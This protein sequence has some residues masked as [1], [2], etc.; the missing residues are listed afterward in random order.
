MKIKVQV[1]LIFKMQKIHNQKK[2]K[3]KNL[4][5]IVIIQMMK[6]KKP[7]NQRLVLGQHSAIHIK[8]QL[9]K[10]RNKP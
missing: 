10:L 1:I 4:R 3:S 7:H 5:I 6:K 9:L 2:K 8:K